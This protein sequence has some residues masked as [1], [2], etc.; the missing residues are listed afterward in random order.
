MSLMWQEFQVE[1]ASLIEDTNSSTSSLSGG[2][3]NEITI[4]EIADP[5]VVIKVANRLFERMNDPS[6][7][8]L[9]QALDD[10]DTLNNRPTIPGS[11]A[12][13]MEISES[14]SLV[15]PEEIGF[16]RSQN[17]PSPG[18]KVHGFGTFLPNP[19]SSCTLEQKR[20]L[21]PYLQVHCDAL[22]GLAKKPFNK[23]EM[24]K[25][26]RIYSS[27]VDY[28]DAH[29]TENDSKGKTWNALSFTG[30]EEDTS[31]FQHG[32]VT[33]GINNPTIGLESTSRAHSVPSTIY[34]K[35]KSQLYRK[36]SYRCLNV[37]TEL[38]VDDPS[39]IEGHSKESQSI[40]WRHSFT[41]VERGDGESLVSNKR[42][43]GNKLRID[44]YPRIKV[45]CIIAFV[46]TY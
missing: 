17:E 22:D 5:K 43:R 12:V 39:Q 20:K 15:V 9:L 41:E 26:R 32:N 33:H 45:A 25:L 44:S 13:I 29:T 8:S 10:T 23:S 46:S 6:G 35:S 3:R 21:A 36:P 11:G 7:I 42:A 30:T 18:A 40:F 24:W 37:V 16:L 27:P 28:P 34:K 2:S 31:P 1:S 19:Q 4:R 38:N 14:G